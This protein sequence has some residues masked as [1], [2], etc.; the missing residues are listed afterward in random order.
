MVST[1]QRGTSRASHELS[2]R[3]T[4]AG[5]L[6]GRPAGRS[7]RRSLR[8]IWR[9]IPAAPLRWKEAATH[10]RKGIARIA[11]VQEQ[12]L[13]G[14][15]GDGRSQAAW[16][17]VC[18]MAVG[19]GVAAAGWATPQR[20]RVRA[21]VHPDRGV[22]LPYLRDDRRDETGSWLDAVCPGT[23]VEKNGA[24]GAGVGTERT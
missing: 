1:R 5:V 18:R 22:G 3:G 9:T 19:P 17:G 11:S 14:G 12:A 15:Q 2:D 13:L 20:R 16:R 7:S 4:V 8:L 23:E 6:P 10:S 21:L 24:G